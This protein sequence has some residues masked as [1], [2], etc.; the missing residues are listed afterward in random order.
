[1]PQSSCRFIH[2]R[3]RIVYTRNGIVSTV[4]CFIY[5]RNRVCDLRR[6]IVQTQQ[7][8]SA[9]GHCLVSSAARLVG[10]RKGFLHCLAVVHVHPVQELRCE[11]FQCIRDESC[12]RLLAQVSDSDICMPPIARPA[13]SVALTHPL[14]YIREVPTVLSVDGFRVVIYLPPREHEPPHVHVWEGKGE[15]VIELA[16]VRRPQTIR[17]VAHMRTPDVARAFWIV[18]EHTEHLLA[19]WRRYHD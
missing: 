14:G 1:M 9:F 10:S 19:S 6:R 7:P 17:S 13:A 3:R 11:I 12:D 4:D 5:A 16:T 15:V 2:S 8:I 18:E